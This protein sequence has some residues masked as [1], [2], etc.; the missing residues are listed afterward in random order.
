MEVPRQVLQF[1]QA[2]TLQEYVSAATRIVDQVLSGDWNIPSLQ[3]Q[4]HGNIGPAS[5]PDELTG[6][7]ASFT[8]RPAII[9]H[10]TAQQL[11]RSGAG[12][13]EESG[14]PRRALSSAEYDQVRRSARGE[15]TDYRC[16]RVPIF[17]GGQA[18]VFEATHKATGTVVILKKLRAKYPAAYQVARMKREIELGRRLD[19]HPHAMP[20]LDFDPGY[21][22]FVMPY[23]QSTALQCQEELSAE[24]PL[25]AL[26]EAVCSVLA[27]AHREGWVHRDIKPENIL[28]LEG[29]WVLAD[30]GIVRRPPG[31]TTDPQRTRVGVFMGSERFA[32][33]ELYDNAHA[34]NAS[35]DLYSLGQLIGWAVTGEL[36]QPNVALIPKSG[37]WRG[38]VRQATQR[39]PG[40]RPATTE[41]FLKL[42]VQEL[43]APG[44]PPLVQAKRLQKGLEAGSAAAAEELIALAAAHTGNAPLYCDLL[45]T[46][47]VILLMPAILADSHRSVE[48]VRAMAALLGT[49]RS[50]ERGEADRAIM[51]LITIAQ[52]AGHESELDILEEACLGAFEWDAAWDQWSPQREIASWLI[53]ITG[54]V[55]SSVAAALR[56]HPECAAH[57]HH[58]ADDVHVDHRIRAA[59]TSAG[60]KRDASSGDPKDAAPGAL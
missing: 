9:S 38:V 37:P 12:G 22:W 51:W 54:D 25:R 48:V 36:P 13:A 34:V 24:Q 1:E 20:I 40:R 35:T 52:H 30:W 59:V 5:F 57:F 46:V 21:T 7:V 14:P 53:S 15:R 58:L 16:E 26:L 33:P 19:A 31:K 32:A 43:E 28:R 42:I 27:V 50:P 45:V 55:A 18:D 3:Q 39:N 44:E 23:A 49:H 2:R 11:Q 6:R 47:P 29:R 56:Q 17:D 4:K 60:A 8:T 41:D 10:P